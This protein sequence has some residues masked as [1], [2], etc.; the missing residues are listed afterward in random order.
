MITQV[1]RILERVPL[2]MVTIPLFVAVH[3]E[4]QYHGMIDYAL[5]YKDLLALFI[6]PLVIVPV[7]YWLLKRWNKAYLF[8]IATLIIWYF[9]CDV[10]ARLQTYAPDAFYSSYSFLLPLLI[11]LLVVLFGIL[12]KRTE[13]TNKAHFFFNLAFLLFILADAISML[14]VPSRNKDYG[15]RQKSISRNHIPC[16]SCTKPDI[17]YIIFDAYASSAVLQSEF[18]YKNPVDSFLKNRRFFLVGHSRSNY[19]LTPFS[20]SSSFNLD[21]LPHLDAR[22]EIHMD[23]YVPGIYSVYKSELPVILKKEGYTIINH[24]IFDLRGYPLNMPSF[25]AWHINDLY[26]RHQLVKQ[27][28]DDIGWKIKEKMPLLN[29]PGDSTAYA[30]KRNLFLDST[31]QAIRRTIATPQVTPRFVY[32]HFILPHEPYSF[33]SSGRIISLVDYPLPMEKEK[34]AYIQQVAYANRIMQQLVERIQAAPRPA[35]I[36]IQGDH[37]IRFTRQRNIPLEFPNF[38]AIYFY[39]QDYSRL[40]DTMT[41]VNT[42]RVVFNSILGTKYPLLKDSCITLNYK[43]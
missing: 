24:S 8:S 4:Q 21:Y 38:N 34:A 1:K 32:C 6:P 27:V 5:V 37:G 40:N 35:V 33:D 31:W 25:D 39:N 17:Y 18:G 19:N 30:R 23:M 14:L 2:F 22:K 13:S 20:I 3:I 41:N 11:V 9:F 16:D 15:D 36:I 10:K 12:K 7:A 42:F 26:S 43:Q 29:M 28:N